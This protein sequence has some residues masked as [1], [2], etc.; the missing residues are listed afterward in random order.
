MHF[1]TVYFPTYGS[2]MKTECHSLIIDGFVF[3]FEFFLP[4]C[5]CGRMLTISHQTFIHRIEEAASMFFAG[6][7]FGNTEIRVSKAGYNTVRFQFFKCNA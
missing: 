2:D 4:F 3:R 6:E 7:T 5:Q 1:L